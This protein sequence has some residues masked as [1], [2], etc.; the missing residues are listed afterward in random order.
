MVI[1]DFILVAASLLGLA[2]LLNPRVL[3]WR[4]WRAT[5]TPLASI[6]GSGFLVAGPI[7]SQTAGVWAWAAMLGLCAVGYYYGSA[8]RHNIAFVEPSLE[9]KAPDMVVG[10]EEA[11]R[12]ALSLAY[13]VSVTYYLN[14]FSA[15][16]LRSGDIMDDFWIRVVAT[17]VI[18]FIGILG[19][20]RGL[21]ALEKVETYAVGL[22]LSLIGALCL[23][24]LVVSILALRGGDFS[25]PVISHD[26][27]T[28]EIQV[29]LGLVIL[30][31]GFET[32][33][34]LGDEY[35]TKLRIKT[36]RHAQWISTGIYLV[37][38]V[39]VTRYFTT[40]FSG[41]GEETAIIDLLRPVGVLVAPLII[42]VALASQLSA[43]VADMNG[44]GGLISETSG[45]RISVKW[46]YLITASVAV[47]ITWSAN[48]YEIITYASKAFVLYYGLQSLQAALSAL[49]MGGAYA[50]LK[51]AFYGAGVLLALVIVIFAVPAGV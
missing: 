25:W 9:Q 47:V 29:L 41:A 19:L 34:Y 21:G 1:G 33:R 32:S 51:A 28:R 30:V 42:T 49:R 45:K 8:I 4:S 15:F 13:F 24:L 20:L 16:A 11:S 36:M 43:A 38:I 23:A 6:I 14:L 18:A 12:V 50:V 26:A 35:D 5:V 37:F 7:L 17:A 40:N 44:A 48:I 46:G 2:F 3:K 27:G 10:I 22:K 39:L 31:Q